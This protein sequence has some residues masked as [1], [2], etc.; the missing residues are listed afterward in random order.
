MGLRKPVTVPLAVATPSVK[1]PEVSFAMTP[2]NGHADFVH[3][4]TSPQAPLSLCSASASKARKI[5][6]VTTAATATATAAT[7]AAV[8]RGNAVQKIC[9]PLH[10]KFYEAINSKGSLAAVIPLLD[11]YVAVCDDAVGNLNSLN[12]RVALSEVEGQYLH[13]VSSSMSFLLDC[14]RTFIYLPGSSGVSVLD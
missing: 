14:L 6:G 9:A 3:K 2:A 7:S 8:E 12:L 13:K 11:E 10:K 4:F 1:R 5:A